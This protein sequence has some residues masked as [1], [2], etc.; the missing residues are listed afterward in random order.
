VDPFW[1]GAAAGAC[2]TRAG[3]PVVA[4]FHTHVPAYAKYYGHTALTRWAWRLCRRAHRHA[5]LTLVP[6]AAIGQELT[7]H[8]IAP[9]APWPRG[10]DLE[11]FHPARRSRSLRTRLLGGRRHL[12]LYVGRLAREKRI[13]F[14]IEA[15]L[16]CRDH[17]LVVVG[18]GPLERPLRR[19]YA[20]Q[21]VVFTG[22]LEGEDLARHYAS[23]DLF[24]F[25]SQSETY[26][27]VLTE[28]LASGVPVAVARNPVLSEV[29]GRAGEP[30]AFDANDPEQLRATVRRLLEDDAER[31][32]SGL[33]GAELI[34]GRSWE[35]AIDLL[36]GHYQR[37]RAEA[38]ARSRV[39]HE[40]SAGPASACS[41]LV[42][43][44]GGNDTASCGATLHAPAYNASA[45]GSWLLLFV[46]RRWRT[47]RDGRRATRSD[48]MAEL[49]DRI[50]LNSEIRSGKPLI[51]GTRITVADIL[52]YLAGGMSHEE[53]LADFPSLEEAD[54]RAALAFA[55]ERE[56]RLFSAR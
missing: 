41:A 15:L 45:V 30:G 26:G 49:L 32:R 36:F 23:A 19:R 43:P 46:H 17:R 8:G 3:I 50:T 25:A 22:R 5:S 44:P 12:V 47:L 34:R 56:H 28:A 6:T 40:H 48:T 11:L 7:E 18:D 9:V 27:Q 53:I 13:E 38:A 33:A 52:E 10:V 1:F 16:P 24:V 39:A 31:V 20:P 37:I 51:R 21:G 2:A 29:L 55:A 54:I 42:R 35:A 14:L 4:S